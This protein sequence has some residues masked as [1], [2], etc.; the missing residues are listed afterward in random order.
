MQPSP[1]DILR[2]TV[3]QVMRTNVD[4]VV[5][6]AQAVAGGMI[7]KGGGVFVA[8]GSV[9]AAM[10]TPYAGAYCASKAAVT[11]VCD[12]LRMELAPFNVQVLEVVAGA[13]RTSFSDNALK[14]SNL[15]DGS[16]YAKVQSYIHA[17]VTLS[18]G[19]GVMPANEFAATV[20][21]AALAA[22]PAARLVAG[23][24]AIKYHLI[25][26]WYPRRLW[27]K[28]I[29]S[30]LGLSLL[31]SPDQATAAQS[32]GRVLA[33]VRALLD[34]FVSWL[35]DAAV[36]VA[37]RLQAVLRRSSQDRMRVD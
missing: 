4:G 16:R 18:Q 19:A 22:K 25:G 30:R 6:T 3:H 37:V 35:I 24:H 31:Q 26:R 15:P 32:L 12:A 9:S 8:M 34:A 36:A 11:A 2:L 29:S 20:V 28:A 1:C 17:R 21:D 13:I 27:A 14:L 23:G 5:A 10:I 7:D 33:L